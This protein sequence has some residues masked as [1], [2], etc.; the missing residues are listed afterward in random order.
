MSNETNRMMDLCENIREEIDDIKRKCS[1]LQLLL[2]S[3][4][5]DVF[6]KYPE[7]EDIWDNIQF[8]ISRIDSATSEL[9]RAESYF[10]CVYDDIH[11]NEFEAMKE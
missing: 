8:C 4:G 6:D 5:A 7:Q 3:L 1:N 2:D 9:N 11:Y 10:N